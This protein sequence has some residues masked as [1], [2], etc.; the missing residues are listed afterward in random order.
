MR[1]AGWALGCVLAAA[2][3]GP[4]PALV[5][6]RAAIRARVRADA[7]PNYT[8]VQTVNR[9]YY[10]PA[11]PSDSGMCL[12]Q[13]GDRGRPSQDR[14][15]RFVL[16]DRLRL[17]V[18]LTSHGE[19]YSW[20][21][22]SRFEDAGVDA[23]V[24]Q[25]PISTGS[26]GALLTIVFAQDPKTFQYRGAEQQDGRTLLEYGFHVDKADS[27]YK[28]RATSSWE[29]TGYSGTVQLD[30]ETGE[31]VRLSVETGLLPPATGSCQTSSRM[32]FHMA[33]IGDG[34][35]PLPTQARQLFVDLEGNQVENTT[36]FASCREYRGESTISFLTEADGVGSGGTTRQAP[37]APPMTV[38]A[39][40]PFSF[41]LTT[42][43]SADTAAGGDPFT[44]RLVAALRD[45]RKLIAPA[46]ALV[47]GRLLRV[48]LHRTKPQSAVMVLRLRSVE[49]G[50]VKVPLAAGRDFRRVPTVGR[51]GVQVMLPYQWEDNS[52]V[53]QVAGEHAL[54][55]AGTRTDWL[56]K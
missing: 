5:L 17:D 30:A 56:T 45:G 34:E 46:H 50:G 12:A 28:V 54:M 25:G 21:G 18:A 33:R 43:L 20:V 37:A 47:E 19:I 44:G 23:I 53:F 7:L 24:H 35:F 55:K 36:V 15:L 38:P 14:G 39:G 29:Y 32:E 16:T 3:A 42:P 41:E 51:R 52:G 27:H 13:A 1:H 49:V 6:Q 9:D 2:A 40:L 4:D 11:K 48:D 10:R 22:A 8:C 31:P 26:F